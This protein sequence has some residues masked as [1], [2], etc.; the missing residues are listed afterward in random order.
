MKSKRQ[1]VRIAGREPEY[2]LEKLRTDLAQ[3]RINRD[4]IKK[5]LEGEDRQIAYLEEL[6]RQKE[7]GEGGVPN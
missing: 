7:E 5:A 6:I 1:M 4:T 3:A 2:N